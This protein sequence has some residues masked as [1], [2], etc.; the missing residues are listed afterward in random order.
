MWRNGNRIHFQTSI[1]ENNSNVI[2]GA[3]MDLTEVKA[4]PSVMSNLCSAKHVDSDAI[5]GQIEEY[6]KAHTEQVKKINGVF[7]FI[8]TVKGQ[9]ESD[10]GENFF[11]CLI[12][13]FRSMVGDIWTFYFLLCEVKSSGWVTLWLIIVECWLRKHTSMFII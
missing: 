5:F 3:Y 1:V 7:H 11:H 4:T 13:N 2:T 9:P 12:W 6:V 8:I 10:W